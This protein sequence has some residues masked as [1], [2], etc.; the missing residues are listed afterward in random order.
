MNN[1]VALSYLVKMEGTHSQQGPSW[2]LQINMGLS[3]VEKDYNYCIVLSRLSECDSRL[4][5]LQ[6]SGQGQLET[7][8]RGIC[9]NLS[10]IRYT[11]Y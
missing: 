5:V 3:T 10:E 11:Q 9:K 6:F 1:K 7:F 4:G 2:P 8:P